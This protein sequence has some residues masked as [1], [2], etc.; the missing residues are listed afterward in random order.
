M[1]CVALVLS[2]HSTS[3][4]VWCER[5]VLKLLLTG[6]ISPPLNR[7]KSVESCFVFTLHNG[8]IAKRSATTLYYD[9]YIRYLGAS[10]ATTI[11]TNTG[12]TIC[13]A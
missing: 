13:A 2:V 10:L 3:S 9:V 8:E 7:L 4:F 12:C 11:N 6:G 5:Y 1:S